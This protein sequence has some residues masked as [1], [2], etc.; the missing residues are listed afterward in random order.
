MR[1]QGQIEQLLQDARIWKAGQV[2]AAS[3]ATVATGWPDIDHVLGGGWPLGQLTEFLVDAHGFGEFTLLLPALRRL[4]D[5]HDQ[6]AGM[7]GWAALVAPPYTPYAPALARSGLDLSRLLLIDSGEDIETLWAMEQA[8]RSGACSA[9]VGWSA[10]S[11]PALLRRLQLAAESGNSWVV[12][13]RPSRLMWSRSPA[14]LRIH[15]TWAQEAGH[16]MLS[17]L[18]RKGG[19]PLTVGVRLSR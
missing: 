4:T 19:A 17:V 2:A 3:R 8:S 7:S 6:H 10:I 12:V 5:R 18:K 16:L 9:V 1:A 15:L 14:P 13:F 11:E